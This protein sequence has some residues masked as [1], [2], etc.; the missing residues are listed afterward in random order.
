MKRFCLALAI[1]VLYGLALLYGYSLAQLPDT[2]RLF[3][4]ASGLLVATLVILPFRYWPP[5]LMSAFLLDELARGIQI[6]EQ[7]LSSRGHL[8]FF[9]SNEVGGATAALILKLWAGPYTRWLSL[10]GFLRLLVAGGLVGATVS[11]TLGTFPFRSLQDGI[12][13]F[14]H[15][16]L[17]WLGDLLGIMTVGTLVLWIW[18]AFASKANRSSQPKLDWQA[19]LS[20]IGYLTLVFVL[21]NNSRGLAQ[22]FLLYPP[23]IWFAV[24]LG[25]WPTAAVLTTTV[26]VAVEQTFRELGPFVHLSSQGASATAVQLFS[27][28]LTLSS[29]S[30]STILEDRKRSVKRKERVLSELDDSELRY[31]NLFEHAGVPILVV[32]DTRVERANPAACKL[33][34]LSPEEMRVPLSQLSAGEQTSGA[35]FSELWPDRFLDG[36]V[37]AWTSKA[38]DG[39]LLELDLHISK[40]KL[41]EGPHIQL[42]ARDKTRQLHLEEMLQQ[43]RSRLT[44]S[45]SKATAQLE[46]TNHRLE[47]ANL[48]RQRFLA[49][50]SHELRTPLTAILGRAETLLEGLWGPLTTEQEG[51]LRRIVESGQFLEALVKDLLDLAKVG[52]IDVPLEVARYNLKDICHSSVRLVATMAEKK[53]VELESPEVDDLFVEVDSRFCKQILV[54]LLTNAVK[55]TPRGGRVGLKARESSGS[56]TIEVW[57]TGKGM[58]EELQKRLFQPFVREDESIPGFG[59]GL[60]LVKRLCRVMGGDIEANSQLGEGTQFVL[61]FPA[62]TGKLLNPRDTTAPTLLIKEAV[63]STLEP[64]ARYFRGRGYDVIRTSEYDQVERLLEERSPSLAFIEMEPQIEP[65]VSFLEKLRRERVGGELPA[66]VILAQACPEECREKLL[67]AG[68]SLIVLKPIPLSDLEQLSEQLVKRMKL[69]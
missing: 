64:T 34:Q 53:G 39:S 16:R 68:A 19:A 33:W 29:L 1:S 35:D 13:T 52:A 42:V 24:R 21:F 48:L 58:S 67:Q 45:V 12:D 30:I 14:L 47:Q 20:L 9:F 51:A 3:W 37:V 69:M 59:L 11:A 15:W 44:G 23:L 46:E 4:P 63:D 57:D 5:I 66:F 40:V 43:E 56:I 61:T 10:S 18:E 60:A 22:P 41:P 7:P 65:M 28:T 55:F 38:S 6:P 62:Q 2:I 31:E 32:S 49:T 27:I 8:E 50:I 26:V 25:P 54:N 36:A 17:W